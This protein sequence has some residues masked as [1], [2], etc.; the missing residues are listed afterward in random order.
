MKD[1]WTNRG[2]VLRVRQRSVAVDAGFRFL[3]GFRDHRIGQNTALISHFGFLS[4]FPLMLVATTIL[5]FVL[6][7]HP[8]LRSSIIDSAAKQ[9]P[10]IGAEI[11]KNP[12]ALS[13]NVVVLVAGLLGA[14]WASTK[15]FVAMQNGLNDIAEVPLDDRGN[16][17]VS[18]LRALFG[19]AIIGGA[20]IATAFFSTVVGYAVI[21]IVGRVLLVAATLAVNTAVLAG[22]YRW[23]TARRRAW[24]QLFPG[25]VVG[26]VAYTIFQLV[27]ATLVSR[28]I[29]RASPVYGTFATVIGVLSWLSLHAL[30]ALV[31]AEINQLRSTMA[32]L[33]TG[34]PAPQ[35]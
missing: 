11:A 2:R 4:V 1:S 21:G 33:R 12:E 6:D 20:Q 31:G 8:A 26:G 17:A 28:A 14:I 13:G 23:L 22:T 15:A 3:D 24:R 27:G 10:I 25:A 29:A 19:I 5:G 35:R 32:G 18:R 7:G 34:R 16:A 30:V 9:I